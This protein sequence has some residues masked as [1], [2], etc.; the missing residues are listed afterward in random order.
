MQPKRNLWPLGIITAFAVFITGTSALVVI[1]SSHRL[2]LVSPDYYEQE[3]RFQNHI[4]RDA[5]TRQLATPATI[6]YDAT[7]QNIV[8]VLPAAPEPQ[9]LIGQIQLYRPSSAGLDRQIK[10]ELNSA[11][12]QT[13]DAAGLQHGLWNIRVSWSASGRDYFVEKR[14]VISNAFPH[15]KS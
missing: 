9:P 15:L 12:A 8:I 3:I 7:A 5:R 1:A 13:L 11:G 14:I 6:S 4:D 2:D 10:L